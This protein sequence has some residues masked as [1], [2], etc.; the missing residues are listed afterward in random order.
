MLVINPVVSGDVLVS[1]R[2]N[3]DEE[4]PNIKPGVSEHEE[5][6]E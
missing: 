2:E 3:L 6:S 1:D 5:D 4:L